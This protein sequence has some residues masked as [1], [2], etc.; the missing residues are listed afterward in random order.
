MAKIKTF[1]DINSDEKIDK[2]DLLSVLL[3]HLQYSFN[4]I[5]S[6]D[7][8]TPKEKKIITK[9]MFDY[10]TNGTKSC[11]GYSLTYTY[12]TGGNG[13]ETYTKQFKSLENAIKKA[14]ELQDT[15]CTDFGI[16]YKF[17][18]DYGDNVDG[19]A[20]YSIFK[21]IY[22]CG[23]FLTEDDKSNRLYIEIEEIKFL[24]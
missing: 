7:E 15:F 6:Y 22:G 24:D 4:D 16:T 3:K 2:S 23:L 18:H 1:N 9:E 10:L 8:L 5:N 14:K 13:V 11:D 17:P 21:E 19:E 20:Y 12:D